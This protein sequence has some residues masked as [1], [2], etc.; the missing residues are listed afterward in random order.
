MMV[1]RRL[2]ALILPE[3][4]RI[5]ATAAKL[6]WK[7]TLNSDIG[8]NVRMRMAARQSELSP[9]P[10]RCQ[11]TAAIA[12]AAM[13]V[14]RIADADMP[15]TKRN[16]AMA[17]IVMTHRNGRRRSRSSGRRMSDSKARIMPVWSPLMASMWAIPALENVARVS[18]SMIEASPTTA[19]QMSCFASTDKEELSTKFTR[20]RRAWSEWEKKSSV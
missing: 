3:S 8:E 17:A 2:M 6:S 5:A 11:A 7:P 19:V 12:V 9:L 13:M 16:V 10:S 18:S 15:V 4:N 1:R 20:L 14:A